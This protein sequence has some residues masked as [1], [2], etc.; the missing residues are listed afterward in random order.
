V[1]SAHVCSKNQT[2]GRRRSC[3]SR[4]RAKQSRVLP[5]CTLIACTLPVQ[6]SPPSIPYLFRLMGSRVMYA[7]TFCI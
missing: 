1:T 7:S 6:F 3:R 4:S 2:C 5:S